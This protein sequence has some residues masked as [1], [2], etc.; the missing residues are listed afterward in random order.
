MKAV[1]LIDFGSTYTKVTGV[2]LESEEILA[3]SQSFTTVDT[4]ICVGLEKAISQLEAQT[5]VVNWIHKYGC[6]SAAGGLRMV[7]VGLVRDLTSKAASEAALSAGAKLLNVYSME[8]TDE[9]IESIDALNPDILLLTG[10]TDGGNQKIILHNA[11]QI[12]KSK[13]SYPIIYSGNRSAKS[14]VSDILQTN[15]KEV[16][17]TEN[18]M[19]TFGVLNILPARKA[20]QDLFIH[21]IIEAKG[22]KNAE[23]LIDNVLMPTPLA[24]MN[25]AQLL[26]DGYSEETGLG[27]IIVVDIGG[28]TTDIH[29]VCDGLPTTPNVV[30]KGIEEPRVK[31]SVEG[32]LG[33]RYSL[34]SALEL[35]DKS[36][37]ANE[38]N[39][40][41][42][43]LEKLINTLISNPE[44][45]G[46]EL[47]RKDTSNI[48]KDLIRDFDD[49]V[50]KLV[51]KESVKRHSGMLKE[52][53]TPFGMSYEQFGK[54]LTNV[55][56]II[57]TGGPLIHSKHPKEIL[58]GSRFD[59]TQPFV[60]KPKL[61]TYYLDDDYILAAMG[62]LATTHKV[63]AYNIL[64][65]HLKSLR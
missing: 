31:R 38:L 44:L 61:T 32:D 27:D 19:P 40:D 39:I 29:S 23:H 25:G 53:Y 14:Q 50:A 8:L 17:P 13:G 65:K 28:A 12:A 64:T 37:L 54:D 18:V 41:I 4:D 46:D 43:E 26:G 21:K 1:M 22:I 33:A 60:L 51:I 57:G 36:M 35:S 55:T 10:G 11:K 9:D 34:D 6:S 48:N 3:T 56:T 59:K 15:H 5:G 16:I 47:N 24:V 52:H 2:D 63:S 7:A 49:L 45:T 62:L 42:D 20:I 58:E 30:L